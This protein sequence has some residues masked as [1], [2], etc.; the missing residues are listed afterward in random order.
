MIDERLNRR[1]LIGG[2][3]VAGL[4]MVTAASLAAAQDDA[5]TPEGEAAEGEA[6][7]GV[8]EEVQLSQDANEPQEELGPA[9]PPEFTDADTNWPTEHG[10][11]HGTRA[12]RASSITADNIGELGVAWRLPI[13]T[14][15]TYGSVTASPVIVGN[16]VYVAD[17]QS[18]IWS[19]N[20]E[21]GEVNWTKEYNVSL[22]GPNGLAVAYG[23]L[24]G[25]LGDT[26]EVVCIDAASGDEYWRVQL[27][28]NA[29]QQQCSRGHRHCPVR[30]R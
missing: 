19:I 29:R 20:K 23:R 27:S 10:D 8:E 25:V 17:M 3:S 21:T 22:V 1:R 15:G 16:T 5:A 26:S 24:Y 2:A 4:S 30:L 11:L 18:N 14:P 7:G 9:V 6:Q 28:N 12:A 13:E